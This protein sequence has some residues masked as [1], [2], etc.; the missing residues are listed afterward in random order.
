[1][2]IGEKLKEKRTAAGLSQEALSHQIGVS[3]QTI[4]SWENDRSYPDI[5]SILKLSDLYG[6]SLDE[7][8]KE[9]ENMRKHIEKSALNAD[10]I[11]NTALITAVLLMPLSL[12][13]SHWELSVLGISAKIISM[14]MMLAVLVFR[15]KL[16]GN[17][18]Y[19]LA[20]GLV[21]WSVY[22]LP[23]IIAMTDFA[24]TAG[25]GPV[26]SIVAYGTTNGAISF[27]YVFFGILLFYSYGVLFK[28]RLAFWQTIA[29]YY[30]VPLYI[31]IATLMPQIMNSNLFVK[32]YDPFGCTYRVVEVSHGE[33]APVKV[34]LEGDGK[35]LNLDN[36]TIGEFVK[37]EK[38]EGRETQVWHLVPNGVR[39][40]LIVLTVMDAK[41]ETITLERRTHHPLPDGQESY[42]I[43]WNIRLKAVPTMKQVA[44]YTQGN[45]HSTDSAFIFWHP[46]E[47]E[48][49]PKDYTW[50]KP[51]TWNPG[52]TLSIRVE[53]NVI[54]QKD[55][56]I[57]ELP[58]IVELHAGSEVQTME[59]LLTLGKND[60]FALPEE[61][62]QNWEGDF[63]F[64][65]IPWENGEYVF[66]IDL[67]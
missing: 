57:R 55:R 52:T 31:G 9:D 45:V 12:L 10:K 34:S 41:G 50:P 21:F 16:S 40:D 24:N 22:Y 58:L 30:G 28:T 18:W 65:R 39:S 60:E 8:L 25:Y 3:R 54:R 26:A 56:T 48:I 1:M 62:Y 11:L 20:I 46:A 23:S 53:E 4:S 33:D 42:D 43:L 47:L 38:E 37:Q 61:F 44:R 59:C 49:V 63:L 19:T 6:M 27:E 5:G 67:P 13:L 29:I 15:W 35:T 14:V 7:L 66:R 32:D 36:V 2:K 51:P 17:R 64:F